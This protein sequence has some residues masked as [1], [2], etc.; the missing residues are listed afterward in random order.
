[1]ESVISFAHPL[2]LVDT[3]AFILRHLPDVSNH[4][5]LRLV[6][7]SLAR[8]VCTES[9]LL[10]FHVVSLNHL[11]AMKQSPFVGGRTHLQSEDST[12]VIGGGGQ[13]RACSSRPYNPSGLLWM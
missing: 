3:L 4:L 9:S 11:H 6:C 7:K 1:M 10:W 12:Y 5:A 8:D 2:L 13:N